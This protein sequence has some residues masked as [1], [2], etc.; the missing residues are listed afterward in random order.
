MV[1]RADEGAAQSIPRLGAMRRRSRDRIKRKMGTA[2]P[3]PF[4]RTM[5]RRRD[6]GREAEIS[7]AEQG[8][9]TA[10]QAGKP[11]SSQPTTQESCQEQGPALPYRPSLGEQS[12]VASISSRVWRFVSRWTVILPEPRHPSATRCPSPYRPAMRTSME[13]S[14]RPPAAGTGF[15]D[16]T[17]VAK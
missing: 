3:R 7:S 8:F 17:R 15:P 4:G 6:G 2:F 9:G 16:F 14:K 5:A 12:G 10:G 13:A 1:G 11:F